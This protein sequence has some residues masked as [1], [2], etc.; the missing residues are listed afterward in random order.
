MLHRACHKLA[1]SWPLHW[2]LC[3]LLLGSPAGALAATPP[4]EPA[5]NQPAWLGTQVSPTQHPIF[6]TSQRPAGDWWQALGDPYLDKYITQ[7]LANNHDL[8]IANWRITEAQ[9]IVREQL[10][11]ELPSLTLNP[12][13]NRQRNS[14]NLTRPNVGA[15]SGSSAT[16]G[17][18]GAPGAR[19][20]APGQTFNIYSAPLQAS[21]ELDY[22]LQNRDL[23]RSKQQAVEA[24]V[25]Q[26]RATLIR[27]V[28]EVAT[29]Y[30]NLLRADALVEAQTHLIQLHQDALHLAQTNYDSGLA[31]LQPVQDAQTQLAQAQAALPDLIRQQATFS[32]QMAVLMGQTPAQALTTAPNTLSRGRLDQ[33]VWPT[34]LSVGVPAELVAQ[35]PDILAAEHDLARSQID[36]R[37]ARKGLFPSL[38]LTGQFGF[39]ST[40]LQ[41]LFRWDS[42]IAGVGAG[43]AQSVFAGGS[44]RA[45]LKIAKARYEQQLHQ[46]HQ[47]VLRAFQ[48]VEDSL[49]LITSDATTLTAQQQALASAQTKLNLLQSR[50]HAGLIAYP[51]VV[52]AQKQLN[53]AQQTVLVT[54]GHQWLD[55]VSLYKAVGG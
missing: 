30:L 15:T 46:Y 39:A 48:D 55:L 26:R 29:A 20:F 27:L 5:P 47:T 25:A 34:A 42:Y 50:Y 16:T 53:Q 49:A 40:Q 33:L 32:H 13:F 10:G 21:Y 7:A 11:H 31:A 38:T 45:T 51:E 2:L 22:L 52:D 36:V 18:S 4:A 24:L 43:L 44:K 6:D 14:A 37:V 8:A 19:L 1:Q 3:G 28:A 17:V 54:N 35:R 41:D 23:T 9:A 12:Q